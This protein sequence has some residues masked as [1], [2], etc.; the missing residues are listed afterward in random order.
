MLI[1]L[2]VLLG[3]LPWAVMRA[4]TDQSSDYVDFVRT[5]RWIVDNGY[6]HPYTAL[7]RYLPSVDVA[8]I[9]LTLVPVTVGATIYYLLNVGTWFGLLRTIRNELLPQDKP[10]LAARGTMAAALLALIIAADGFMIAAFHVLMV[11]LMVAGLVHSVQGRSWKGG[12]LVGL[13]AWLKLLPV[14]AIGYLLLKGKWRP[15][16]IALAVAATID[17]TLSVAAFGPQG[18]WHEHLVFVSGGAIGTVQDQMEGHASID[19]DR[20]TNE[21]TI[22]VLRRLLTLRGGYH[23]LAIADLSPQALSIVTACVLLSIT[24]GVLFVLRRPASALSQADWGG[25]IALLAL[26]TVWLSPVVWSYHL[27]AAVPALAVIMAQPNF[28][29]PKRLVA[30][31]WI[32]AMVLFTVPLARTAGHMLWASYFVGAVLVWAMSRNQHLEP[33][34]LGMVTTLR[35]PHRTIDQLPS[36]GLATSRDSGV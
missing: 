18:A 19:E 36:G 1:M 9:L 31:V 14:I 4:A 20:I 26:C 13:A 23:S 16:V 17:M 24:G 10:L 2:A 29:I 27:T 28:E 8:C 15:A 12:A 6:R 30:I 25:E 35:G 5:G 33:G 11:W 32:G 22:V 34:L 7:N 3:M 21:S